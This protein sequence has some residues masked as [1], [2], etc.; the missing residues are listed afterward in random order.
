MLVLI[1]GYLAHLVLL[2]C[3]FFMG[4]RIC[5]CQEVTS[6]EHLQSLGPGSFGLPQKYTRYIIGS[7]TYTML[8]FQQIPKEGVLQ[9]SFLHT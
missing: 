5:K 9:M 2:T 1:F 6:H 7:V 3:C 4:S 8:Q